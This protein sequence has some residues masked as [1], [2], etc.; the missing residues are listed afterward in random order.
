VNKLREFY[1]K[2]GSSFTRDISSNEHSAASLRNRALELPQSSDPSQNEYVYCFSGKFLTPDEPGDLHS[3]QQ[4][5]GALEIARM[6]L[7]TLT[8]NVTVQSCADMA[9]ALEHMLEIVRA[10]KSHVEILTNVETHWIPAY[11]P[12]WTTN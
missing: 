11:I 1:P 4:D 2:A 8:A 7:E 12:C 5:R 3:R 10:P 9:A 6:L